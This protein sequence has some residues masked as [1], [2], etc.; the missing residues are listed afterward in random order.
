MNANVLLVVADSLRARNTSVT[1]YRRETT[2]FLSELATE[3]TVFRQARSPS[4]WTLPSH[5]SLFTGHE[6]PAHGFDIDRRLDPGHTVFEEL[7]DRGYDTGLFSDNPFL[8]EHESGLDDVFETARGSPE[9]FP[10]EYRT[11][12]DLGDW[13]NG[14]WYVEQFLSWVDGENLNED[15]GEGEGEGGGER[16]PE[17]PF[18]ACLNL[19]DT[20]R[21]YEP[22]AEYDRWSDDSVRAL[23]EEMGFKWHWEFLSGRVSTGFARLLEAVYD[24]G[25][26]QLDA[27]VE[28][29]AAGLDERGFLDDTLLVVTADHGEAFGE[30]T[31]L[32]EEPLAVSHR[33]GTH[34][35]MYHVP[36]VVKSPG[37]RRGRVVDDLAGL[38][39]FADAVRAL[40][41]ENETGVDAH[42]LPENGRVV[43]EQ[44]PIAEGM[45]REAT[46]ITGDAKPYAK[47]ATLVYEDRVGDRVLKRARWG[48]AAYETLV[49]GRTERED[50]GR[51][52][53]DRVT[54]TADTGQVDLS[55]PLEDYDQFAESYQN[56]F[57]ADLEDRLEALG[58]R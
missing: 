58:Y 49:R 51:V 2:P 35:S 57:A 33:I 27:I 40:V 16:D 11:N 56:E 50:R 36:L 47:R 25:V 30:E 29:L 8:T 6:A 37:Q 19:M 41:F 17:A 12:G 55:S 22:L 32:P 3:A 20:H 21:P 52:D 4:N 9:T 1:G 24:G 5:V 48:D 53:P 46:R 13:P 28:R 14:F 15:E 44:L 23:Q 38:S 26:R 54:A 45:Q 39:G 31:S 10:D 18:A 43:A 7:E 34:E 42:F